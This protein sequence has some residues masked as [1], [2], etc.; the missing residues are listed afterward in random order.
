MLP[1]DRGSN[2]ILKLDARSLPAGFRVTT[3]NP[4]VVRLTPGMMSEVNFGAA[5]GPVARVDLADAAFLDDGTPSAALSAG[6]ARL[7]REMAKQPGTVRLAYHVARDASVAD[8]RV[9]RQ[10]MKRV[11]KA[12]KRVWRDTGRGQLLIEQTIRRAGN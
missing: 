9:A 2:F 11:A 7:A 8:V 3:E 10:R 1:A 12:L 6:L 5:I 4:R